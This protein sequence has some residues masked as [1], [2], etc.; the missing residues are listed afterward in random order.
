MGPLLGENPA[1]AAIMEDVAHI[2]GRAVCL[3]V[4][5]RR[6]VK[7]VTFHPDVR[8]GGEAGAPRGKCRELAGEQLAATKETEAS[9]KKK[10]SRHGSG[11]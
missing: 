8:G 7:R 5:V 1:I 11:Q 9:S 2:K 6:V 4:D 3:H 10:R